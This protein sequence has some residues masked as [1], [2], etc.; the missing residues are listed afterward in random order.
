LSSK[1]N[2]MG[3]YIGASIGALIA[4]AVASIYLYN[5]CHEAQRDDLADALQ[6][7]RDTVRQL[8]E[9]VEALRA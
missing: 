2:M 1:N 7:A 6:E 3:V 9:A 4:T 8:T 5:K